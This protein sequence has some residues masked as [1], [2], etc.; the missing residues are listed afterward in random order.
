MVTHINQMRRW[1]V[2]MFWM[3]IQPLAQD[4]SADATVS[5]VV[6]R[7]SSGKNTSSKSPNGTTFWA[8]EARVDD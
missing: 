4:A 2:S 8:Y 1:P 3:G 7:D 6:V 5:S